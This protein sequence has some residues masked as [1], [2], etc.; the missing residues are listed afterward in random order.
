L[1]KNV[2]EEN[3]L[4]KIQIFI[5]CLFLF[6]APSFADELQEVQVFFDDY[7]K[8]ANSYSKTVTDYYLPDAK[9]IRVVIKPDG[10]MQSVTFPMERYKKELKKGQPLARLSRYKNTYTNKKFEKLDDGGYKISAIRIPNNDKKGLPF[11]FIVKNT[12][13]GWKVKEESMQTTVQKFLTSK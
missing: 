13:E 4:R 11:H 1:L 2:Y 9:I 12:P 10:S 6:A 7:V 3:M 5:I 8:A